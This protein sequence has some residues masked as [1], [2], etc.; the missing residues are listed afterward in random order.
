MKSRTLMCITTMTFF[1][2]LAMPI[3]LAAQDQQ[4]QAQKKKHSRYKLIDI[5]TFGG[6]QSYELDFDQIV[7]NQGTVA[8]WAD[9]SMPD[10][11]PS[12]CFNSD[13]FVSH[14]FRRK[15]GIL[16]D[17][18]ALAAGW[19][20]MAVW[21]SDNGLVDGTAQNGLIDPLTG[22]PESR[23][24]IWKDGQIVD[25]GTLGGN[26]SFAIGI[27]S[28]GQVVGG[29]TN[30]VPDPFS[31]SGT[32]VRAFLW[33]NGVIQDLGTLGG[34][35]ATAYVVNERG[36]VTG[37][38]YTNS[39]PNPISD[40]CGQNVPRFDPFVWEN[41]KLIDLGTVGGACGFG[42]ALNN[43][44]QVVGQSDL[45]GD[46]YFH[47]FLWDQGALTDL[48]TFGGNY[49][50]ANWLNDAGEIVG[51]GYYPGDQIFHAVLWKN[52]V[53]T[54]LGT[55]PG[56]C[57]S[58]ASYMNSQAQVVG[59]SGNSDFSVQRAFLWE[60][61]GPMIDLNTLIPSGSP[62]FLERA[63]DINDRGE[64][65]GYGLLSNGDSRAFL[66]IP[67]GEGDEGCG[68]SAASA[69]T[70][71]SPALVTRPRTIATPANPTLSGRGMLG[72]LRAQRFPG[73]RTLGLASGQRGN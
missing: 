43:R 38:S 27:N 29:A 2:A 10:P 66:L 4:Q 20:S 63:F 69:T 62:L 72:R 39:T 13:C 70:Q 30:V 24:V 51:Y 8:G 37:G 31:G 48:G 68:D 1:A 5:G 35:D 57:C 33:E 22:L 58:D 7:N 60:D 23:A 25:L 56:D 59:T 71:S 53:M 47:P 46:V 18:G 28:L 50:N 45:A 15:N 26:E 61:G 16:T 55:V 11:F 12:A 49:G 19:S 42:N 73:R 40:S 36:Q 41:G 9:T 34:P 21:I 44:G 32:Q 3:G 64:I 67:C 65:I 17:L 6:P 14:G 52:G 54:D